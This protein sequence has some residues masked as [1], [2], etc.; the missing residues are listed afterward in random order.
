MQ[1]E[2][3]VF[4]NGIDRM[5]EKQLERNSLPL[6]LLPKNTLLIFRCLVNAGYRI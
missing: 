3:M 1:K 4:S 6:Q 2:M 5:K